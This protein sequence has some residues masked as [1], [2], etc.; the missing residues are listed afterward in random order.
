MTDRLQ[1]FWVAVTFSPSTEARIRAIQDNLADVMPTT[2]QKENEPHLSLLPGIRLPEERELEF[3]QQTCKLTTGLDALTVAGLDWY[4]DAAPYV[5]LL[6]IATDVSTVREDLLTV[7]ADHDGEIVYPPTE[8]HITL[9]KSGDTSAANRIQ[10]GDRIS[11]IQ[12]TV[13]EIEA[14]DGLSTNWVADNIT[15]EVRRFDV[16]Q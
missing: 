5:V 12:S 2:F 7:V 1:E 13:A 14:S 16:C 9:F 3:R 4:P 15:I 10:E 8:P 6:D 11:T